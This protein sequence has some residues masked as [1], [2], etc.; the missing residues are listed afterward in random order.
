MFFEAG[1]AVGGLALGALADVFDKRT[2]FAAAVGLC[3]VGCWLLRSVVI[4]TA[5]V[6]RQPVPAVAP[7]A[8]ARCDL[9]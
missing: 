1:T 8:A 4:P 3:V 9:H 7:L 6:E 2:G 5:T